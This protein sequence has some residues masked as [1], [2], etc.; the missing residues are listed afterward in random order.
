MKFEA[1]LWLWLVP[2]VALGATGFLLGCNHRRAARLRTALGTPLLPRLTHALDPRRRVLKQAL[3]VAALALITL[4][5]AQPQQ[6]REPL[7]I[8]RTGVDVVLALDV[9]RSMLAADVDGTNRLAAARA[10]LRNLLER[11]GGD[12]VG[13]VAFAGEA[14]LAAPLTRDHVAVE[15]A[16]DSLT[17][18]SV[19]EPGSN[20]AKAIER[21]REGFDRGSEGPRVLLLISDGEQL[22]GDSAAAARAAVAGGVA[23]HSAGIGSSTG[24][25]LPVPGGFVR[26]AFGR[27]VVSRLDERVLL[28]TA[29]AGRGRYVRIVG[30]DSDVLV[31]WFAQAS[32]GLPRSTESRGVGDPRERFQWPLAA[33]LGLLGGEW[34]LGERRRRRKGATP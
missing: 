19:S 22:Q 20:L 7:K 1:P 26:N 24:A 4:A 21:A 27:E 30:R 29:S 18:A 28:Q 9:S 25:R 17:P 13:L 12:R 15:R 5:L 32:A 11:L 16:L 33:A 34:L 23:V 14:F 2:I 31:G 10:A 6:G 8:E 3:V